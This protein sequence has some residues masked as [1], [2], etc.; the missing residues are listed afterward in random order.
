MPWV[1]LPRRPAQDLLSGKVHAA[2]TAFK[3]NRRNIHVTTERLGV[4][5]CKNC[6]DQREAF[7]KRAHEFVQK[8]RGS[9]LEIPDNSFIGPAL[10]VISARVNRRYRAE[11]FSRKALSAFAFH[12]KFLLS[13]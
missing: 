9:S 3:S 4:C 13:A 10:T 7:Y 11:N 8:N 6:D 2:A 1:F 12:P 5:V